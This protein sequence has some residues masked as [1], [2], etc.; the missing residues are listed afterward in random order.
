MNAMTTDRLIKGEV[1][2]PSRLEVLLRQFRLDKWTGNVQLNIKD[3]RIV[4]LN[5][6]RTIVLTADEIK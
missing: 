1:V 2:V 4:S 6:L 5:Q 3:G